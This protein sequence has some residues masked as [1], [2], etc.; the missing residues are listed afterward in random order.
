M[1]SGD[2][3]RVGRQTFLTTVPSFGCSPQEANYNM[4]VSE[5]YIHMAHTLSCKKDKCGRTNT[6]PIVITVAINYSS[7]SELDHSFLFLPTTQIG[8]SQT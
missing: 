3:L 7:I 2:G 4:A 8:V 1:K 6:F 5:K